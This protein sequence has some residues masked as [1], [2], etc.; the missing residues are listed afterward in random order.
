MARFALLSIVLLLL[1]PACKNKEKA[2]DVV[3]VEPRYPGGQ[4]KMYE[5]LAENIQYPESA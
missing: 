4:E 5:F 3:E 1:L 2:S